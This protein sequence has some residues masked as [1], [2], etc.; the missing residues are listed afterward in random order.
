MRDVTD[1]IIPWP[2]GSGEM[3]GQIRANAWG[4]TPLGPLHDSVALLL[5][6]ASK[7]SGVSPVQTTS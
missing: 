3:A 2:A 1:R 4:S 5:L 7:Y 6:G